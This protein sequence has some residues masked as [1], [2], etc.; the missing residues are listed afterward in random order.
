MQPPCCVP[1][2]VQVVTR[3][4]A[5]VPKLLSSGT[6]FELGN[7]V[8]EYDQPIATEDFRQAALTGLYSLH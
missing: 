4:K 7:F 5:K 6:T 2:P 1:W 8:L 3:G